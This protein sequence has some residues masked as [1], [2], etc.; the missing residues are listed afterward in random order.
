MNNYN[1][2]ICIV[3]ICLVIT[4]LVIFINH[5]RT[6][7]TIDRIENMLNEAAKGNF[8]E[9]SFDETRLSSLESRFAHYLSASVVSARNV[10]LEKDKIKSL[11]ADI[12]HQTKTPIAN[13]LLY[14]E[15][16]LEDDTD[17]LSVQMRENIVQL[18]AQS[19]KLQFLIASLVKLSRLENGILQL[20]PQEEALK[21][22][23]T[24]AVKETEF[25]ARA[26]GLELI[27]HD[28]DEKA[29]FDSKW[30]LEAIC[31]ILDNALKYTNEGTISLSVTAYEMFVRFVAIVGT[32]GS[33]K[34][35][36]LHMLGGLDRPSSG[37]VFVDGKDIFSLKDEEL[38][39]FRR[40]KIGFVFQ[41]YN[42]VP[43]LNVYENIV[44]PI[45]LDGG[46]VD[47]EFVKKITETLG[48]DQ[49][50]DALPNQLSGGQQQRVAIARAL[51]AEPAII[52]ADEPTGNLD[53]RTSQDVLGLLKVT[54][55]KF[56]QTIVMITHNEEIAQLADR[57][58]RIEDGHIQERA[59]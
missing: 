17:N 42:L 32:S 8:S 36:L 7:K 53:G 27:L 58:I 49:R 46:K 34:S 12:S 38:T 29:Y 39:I 19:E 22:M 41:A 50:L 21:S 43:V 59:V 13:L 48:L 47:K 33:G 28:T 40:R 4:A 51:A 1:T 9:K 26:K 45:E 11:I 25:K 5:L 35:T 16:L 6:K 57:I 52:L 3:G 2:A 20:S 18:H 55:Q 30:T 54:S 31:N 44:L 10:E 24:L 23:L 15:L 37:K 56:S 14:S